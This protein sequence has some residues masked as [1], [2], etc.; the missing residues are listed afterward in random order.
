M[1][2][3]YFLWEQNIFELLRSSN[4]YSGTQIR[5]DFLYG[6]SSGDSSM[7]HV[8]QGADCSK[9]TYCLPAFFFFIF[10]TPFF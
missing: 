5:G 7:N 2:V 6:D 9:R 1:L 3:F 4:G 10:L 8:W